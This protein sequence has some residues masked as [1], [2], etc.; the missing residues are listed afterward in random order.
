VHQGYRDL[1]AAEPGR[2]LRIDAARTSDAVQA[3]I[4]AALMTRAGI[5]L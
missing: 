1:M 4:R 3:D 5:T 2:W